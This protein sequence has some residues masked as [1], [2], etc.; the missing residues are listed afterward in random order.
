MTRVDL[1]KLGLQNENRQLRLQLQVPPVVNNL[2]EGDRLGREELA[3]ETMDQDLWGAVTTADQIVWE[4]LDTSE[5]SLDTSE[6][7]LDTS[8]PSLMA[9]ICQQYR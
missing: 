1:E 8:E 7:S 9:R 5:P 4:R 2:N 6:P 3:D